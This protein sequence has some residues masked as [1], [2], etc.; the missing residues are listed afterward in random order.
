M[1][2]KFG[3]TLAEVLITL[4]IIGVVAALTAPALVKNT[5]GAQIGP[6]LAKV[7]STLENAHQ[8]MMTDEDTSDLAKIGDG[9]IDD[10]ME[11]LAKYISGS[12]YETTAMT[13]SDFE[14][15]A[16]YYNGNAFSI[17]SSNNVSLIGGATSYYRFNFSDNIVLLLASRGGLKLKE[18]ATKGSFKGE[19]T[20]MYVDINGMQTKPNVVGRDIFAFLIDRSGKVV[21][22][23]SST[24]DWLKLIRLVNAVTG[25]AEKFTWNQTSGNYACNE[26]TVGTGVGCAGSIFENNLKVIYQ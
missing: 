1:M 18:F 10:Y 24:Y 6:T 25:Q 9:S 14:P 26:T 4:G 21:P 2:K 13:N 7:S 22:V 16:E 3:F 17:A 19:Y 23:G 12:S 20:T 5:S 15:A 8:R 11:T